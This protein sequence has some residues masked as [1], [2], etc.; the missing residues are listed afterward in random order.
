MWEVEAC[1]GERGWVIVE[2][3]R[4]IFAWTQVIRW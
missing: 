4:W 2:A 1:V 3:V